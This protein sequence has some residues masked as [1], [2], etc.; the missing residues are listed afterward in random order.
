MPAEG[1]IAAARRAGVGALGSGVV[2]GAA[3]WRYMSP[4]SQALGRFPYRAD[5]PAPKTVALTFDDGP[6][7][8]YTSQLAQFLEERA[9]LATFFQVGRCVL[10]HPGIT[11]S[12]A[13]AGHVIGNH[14]Y[15]HQ[16]TRCWTRVALTHEIARA[17]EV[18]TAECGRVPALYRPPW[19]ARTPETFDL[20]REQALQPVS[21]EFCHPLEPAQPSA[22]RIAR[23]ALAK[24]RPGAVIIFHDGYD[25]RGG[26]RAHTVE[27]VKIVVDR[28]SERGY[29]FTTVDRLLGLTPY[30]ES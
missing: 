10:R 16:F 4:Y 27:A 29:G 9:I 6:N 8:P 5:P 23:R 7:E 28:L 3:Y 22:E 1:L 14:S 26:P 2:L 15:S 17:Q 13:Q 20:L 21:G 12:L 25:G 11:A 19:L 30:Q 18:I 24:V